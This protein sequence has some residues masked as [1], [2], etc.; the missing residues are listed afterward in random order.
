M[1]LGTASGSEKHGLL[2]E[3]E[4]PEEQEASESKL[5]PEKEIIGQAAGEHVAS[6]ER[7]A[8]ASNSQL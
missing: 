3:E 2:K 7:T 1:Y 5:D 8:S 6:R 4:R